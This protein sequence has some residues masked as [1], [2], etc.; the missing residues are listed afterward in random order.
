[1]INVHRSRKERILAVCFFWFTLIN[2]MIKKKIKVM[3]NHNDANNK[4]KAP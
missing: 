1:M 2:I 4:I 3:M